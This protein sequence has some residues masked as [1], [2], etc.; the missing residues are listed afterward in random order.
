MWIDGVQKLFASIKGSS[1]STDA[2]LSWLFSFCS[3]TDGQVL[4]DVCINHVIAVQA[5]DC[6]WSVDFLVI[7][8]YVA[9][10]YISLFNCWCVVI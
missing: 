5:E 1:Y 9:A 3:L 7:A 6:C 10:G 4:C 8:F 2:S